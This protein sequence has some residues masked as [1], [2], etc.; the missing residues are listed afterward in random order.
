MLAAEIINLLSIIWLLM[1]GICVTKTEHSD[2]YVD[3]KD[4]DRAMCL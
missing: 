1:G 4:I 2:L 3:R